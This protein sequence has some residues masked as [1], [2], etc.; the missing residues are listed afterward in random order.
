MN[1]FTNK[2]LQPVENTRRFISKVDDFLYIFKR[3]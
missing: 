1:S 3:V 2:Q